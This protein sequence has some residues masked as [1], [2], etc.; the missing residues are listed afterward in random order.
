MSTGPI[1]CMPSSP[2]K[3]R[4]QSAANIQNTSAAYVQK[5]KVGSL[6][7]LQGNEFGIRMVIYILHE[8]LK[9]MK[10]ALVL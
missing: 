9:Q 10:E 4:W 7:P 2:V 1:L 6:A 3:N 8:D 5:L